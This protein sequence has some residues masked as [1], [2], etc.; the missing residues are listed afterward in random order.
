MLGSR[1]RPASYGRSSS[2]SSATSSSSRSVLNTVQ[3]YPE[4]S[5]SVPTTRP[6][7]ATVTS[8]QPQAK[9]DKN[10]ANINT[11]TSTTW[12]PAAGDQLGNE[13]DEPNQQSWRKPQNGGTTLKTN[14]SICVFI[15]L[16]AFY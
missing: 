5:S 2:W 8:W 7:W 3:M 4:V 14:L 1:T 9:I 15:V 11:D 10:P 6:D 16:K 12:Y 13:V